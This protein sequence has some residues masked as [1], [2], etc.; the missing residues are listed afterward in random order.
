MINLRYLLNCPNC[1][2]E[3]TFGEGN[4][5]CALCNK[6]FPFVNGT[7]NLLAE[8]KTD[9]PKRISKK[10]IIYKIKRRLFH[11]TTNFPFSYLTRK[12]KKRL[13]EKCLN[14]RDAAERFRRIY[15]PAN[16]HNREGLVL[17]FGCGQGR[18]TAMLSQC[19]FNT[20]GMDPC[21]NAYW[22]N[23]PNAKFIKGTEAELQFFKDNIFDICLSMQVLMYIEND[24]KVIMGLY[25]L[26]KKKGLLILQV[27]NKDNLRTPTNADFL[28]R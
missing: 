20:I 27:T 10:E 24:R 11:P 28:R 19:G 26:L 5:N 8:K 6:T 18:H 13:Y 7:L 14:D 22:K 4:I 15:L 17:D 1:K 12:K 3:F 16:Y 25:R 2:K 9:L 21:D 23:I